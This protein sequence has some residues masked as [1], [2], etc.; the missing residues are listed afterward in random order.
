MRRA[1]AMGFGLGLLLSASLATGANAAGERMPIGLW[2]K[3]AWME[4]ER[5]PKELKALAEH[6]TRHGAT[7]YTSTSALST[8][9]AALPATS[10]PWFES[11]SRP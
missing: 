5:S 6:L 3:H 4:E 11:G 1:V 7:T 9:R 10:P 8:L 2:L